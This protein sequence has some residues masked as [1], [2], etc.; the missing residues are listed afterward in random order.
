MPKKRGGA[1]N[2]PLTI[3]IAKLLS[4]EF[5]ELYTTVEDLK[6]KFKEYNKKNPSEQTVLRQDFEDLRSDIGKFMKKISKLERRALL[7]AII[8][9]DFEK[10][11]NFKYSQNSQKLPDLQGYWKTLI[12][13]LGKYKFGT[14]KSIFGVLNNKEKKLIG[15]A[16]KGESLL[17]SVSDFK[18]TMLNLWESLWA[19]NRG[20]SYIDSK[21]T[22][23][24]DSIY[25]MIVD[26][27]SFLGGFKF[28]PIKSGVKPPLQPINSGLNSSV[29][30]PMAEEIKKEPSVKEGIKISREPTRDELMDVLLKLVRKYNPYKNKEELEAEMESYP[31]EL[32]FENMRGNKVY[33]KMPTEQGEFM[34]QEEVIKFIIQKLDEMGEGEFIEKGV[35]I[36]SPE[37]FKAVFSKETLAEIFPKSE[38]IELEE[39]KKE[40]EKVEEKVEEEKI[41]EVE[42]EKLI[43]EGFKG[44]YRRR[45]RGGMES[46][47][48]SYLKRML[49]NEYVEK[50]YAIAEFLNTPYIQPKTSIQVSIPGGE[51]IEV[52]FPPITPENRKEVEDAIV[53]IVPEKEREKTRETLKE[54]KLEDLTEIARALNININDGSIKVPVFTTKEAAIEQITNLSKG[55]EN[56]KTSLRNQLKTMTN[57]QIQEVAR[58]SGLNIFIQTGAPTAATTAELQIKFGIK[59]KTQKDRLAIIKKAAEKLMKTKKKVGQKLV[60]PKI[61]QLE[62]QEE[63]IDANFEDLKNKIKAQSAKINKRD[64]AILQR[65]KDLVPSREKILDEFVGGNYDILPIAEPILPAK[66]YNKKDFMKEFKALNKPYLKDMEYGTPKEITAALEFTG[67]R[68]YDYAKKTR[69]FNPEVFQ[70]VSY[71]IST[72]D[73]PFNE[74]FNASQRF[75]N[76]NMQRMNVDIDPFSKLNNVVKPLKKEKPAKIAKAEIK[77]KRHEEQEAENVIEMV[78]HVNRTNN[79]SN[80]MNF[81][82]SEDNDI[83]ENHYEDEEATNHI[84][85][86]T[87]SIGLYRRTIEHNRGAMMRNQIEGTTN[88]IQFLRKRLG[89]N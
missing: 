73:F 15:I 60:K 27:H 14:L 29:F 56:A 61:K 28:E 81:Q 20:Y 34:P 84:Y 86:P 72:A 32:F 59:P 23:T 79:I 69:N 17:S 49:E 19:W 82:Y 35:A 18:P 39:G 5:N 53:N 62:E 63:K 33:F 65:A 70:L 36:F 21:D 25:N 85:D 55:N 40:E 43:G 52:E 54:A 37:K 13:T 9:D 80:V 74:E 38:V 2:K 57:E 24:Y 45:F 89:I 64:A 41:E 66:K 67:G 10:A 42:I 22:I 83:A 88:Y 7:A 3:E 31:G 71:G 44:G 76:A 77:P 26:T 12:E 11:C 50:I 46:K 87:G 51:N 48:Q 16:Q 6:E 30:N 68:I 47:K 4:E 78:S 8:F 58:R 1:I 75:Q